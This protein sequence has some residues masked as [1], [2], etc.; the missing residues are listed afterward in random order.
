MLD[1]GRRGDLSNAQN[2]RVGGIRGWADGTGQRGIAAARGNGVR[3]R[4]RRGGSGRPGRGHPP[5]AAGSRG[6]QRGIGR[7]AREGLGGRRAHSV[8]RGHRSDRTGHA[9]SRLAGQGR[10]PRNAGDRGPL[11]LPRPRGRPAHPQHRH[12]A[13]DEQSRQL[14]RQPRQP[15]ALA[16]RAGRRAGRRG[17]SGLRR[18]RGALRRQGRRAGRR[19]RR[20]GRRQEWP[21]DRPLHARHGA[22]RQV[23]HHRRGCARARSPSS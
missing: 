13:A 11:L 8:G 14:H 20:H 9:V 15:H 22:A 4:H 5:E 2:L 16:G 7:R 23:H 18:G 12:A 17:L 1:A 3:R 19:H 21:A 10:A 6:R